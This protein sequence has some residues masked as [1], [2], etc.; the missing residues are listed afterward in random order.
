[1]DA[2]RARWVHASAIFGTQGRGQMK[3][4]RIQGLI[5]ACL[6]ALIAAGCADEGP[7]LEEQSAEE[8]N[9]QAEALF[10][11][12]PSE[13]ARL[14]EELER[15]HPYS[16]L[17]RTAILRSAEA[18]YSIGKYDEA[19]VAGRRFLEFFPGD[20]RVAAARFLVARSHYDRIADVKRD[21][22]SAERA[23]QELEALVQLHPETEY[24]RAA[25]LMIDATVDQL[26]GKEMDVG[27]FYL[28]NGNYLAAIGRFQ[29]VVDRFDT[30]SHVAEALHR[31]V[32]ANLALGLVG[33][34]RRAAAILGH[35]F[36]NS[37]WYADSYALLEGE[38]VL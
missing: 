34:A 6:V 19:V 4:R 12:D 26:A 21:Q 7:S 24:A 22:S 36:Q 33:P 17:A 31:L 2:G 18:Y 23:L 27:R 14:Y 25:R 29:I 30:T 28:N 35:N 11:T 9:Q 3:M 37:V 16:P 1:M 13:A 8:I 10:A 5:A 32:E 38:G 15:L 20:E